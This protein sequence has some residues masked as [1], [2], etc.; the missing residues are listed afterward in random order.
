MKY[1]VGDVLT[2][3]HHMLGYKHGQVLEI[4]T[5]STTSSARYNGVQ[6][7]VIQGIEE[8]VILEQFVVGLYD[9][10]WMYKSRSGN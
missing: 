9:P 1:N 6:Y 8:Y 5:L 7:Y 10:N 3:F 2:V 4:R